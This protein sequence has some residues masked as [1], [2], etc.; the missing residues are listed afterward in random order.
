MS[1]TW[2]SPALLGRDEDPVGAT[3]RG[4]TTAI[5]IQPIVEQKRALAK[6]QREARRQHREAMAVQQRTLE[7]L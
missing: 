2:T 7:G 3:D 6:Q 5:L 1:D 4:D